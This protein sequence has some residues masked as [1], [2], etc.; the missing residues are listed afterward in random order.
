MISEDKGYNFKDVFDN[1]KQTFFYILKNWLKIGLF[2]LLIGVIAVVLI[3]LTDQT[4]KSTISF[5]TEDA[6]GSKLS[7]YAGIAAQFG[8]DLSQGSSGVF[9]GDNILEVFKSQKLIR[10]TLLTP[11]D[12]NNKELFIEFYLKNHRLYN[13]LVESSPSKKLDFQPSVNNF[14]NRYCDSILTAV[15]GSLIKSQLTIERKDRKISL[16]VLSLIDNNEIFAKRFIEALTDN[17]VKFYTEY[18]TKKVKQNVDILQHQADSLNYLLSGRIASVAE[19]IDININP[20]K[21]VARVGTQRKQVDLTI[22]STLYGE[23]LKQL[24]IAKIGLRRETPL[25]QIMDNTDY[26]LMKLR[27]G[28]LKGAIIFSVI[29]AFV[30]V[31]FLLFKRMI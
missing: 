21:Q 24:E 7:G 2:A 17:T 20:L 16:I 23:I 9:E 10:K 15:Y 12:E 28:R 11:V 25:I 6:G 29:G 3:S 19:S 26:P 1:L 14:K 4:Y 13:Q 8:L 22:A 30:F 18:K 27:L 31:I 5:V